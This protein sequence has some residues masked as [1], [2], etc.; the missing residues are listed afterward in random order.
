MCPH[1]AVAH[2]SLLLMHPVAAF[3]MTCRLRAAHSLCVHR[4]LCGVRRAL[5]CGCVVLL[6][7]VVT[8]PSRLPVLESR[9]SK[10]PKLCQFQLCRREHRQLL[11]EISTCDSELR[12]LN[13][14]RRS[15]KLSWCKS[16]HRMQCSEH[17]APQSGRQRP[18]RPW[19]DSSQAC[20]FGAASC[21]ASCSS[22]SSR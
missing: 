17:C 5:Q 2:E 14:R 10:R 18:T 13:T 1:A 20:A 15:L 21:L 6:F 11:C 19:S 16:K 12:L 22:V 4:S 3:A 7:A 8:A 9:R